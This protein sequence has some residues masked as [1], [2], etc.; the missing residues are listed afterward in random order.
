MLTATSP[1]LGTHPWLKLLDERCES[2]LLEI[3]YKAY[4]HSE[5]IDLI[6]KPVER[7]IPSALSDLRWR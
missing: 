2:E 7:P 3:L 1:T 6:G 4:P 5:V